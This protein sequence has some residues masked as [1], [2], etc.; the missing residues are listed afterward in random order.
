MSNIVKFVSIWAIA[1]I[2]IPLIMLSIYGYFLWSTAFLKFSVMIWPS[3]LF[4]LA[5]QDNGNPGDDQIRVIAILTNVVLYSIIGLIVWFVR[6]RFRK[7]E[8]S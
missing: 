7:A 8:R 1:G 4:L 2:T 6:S 3:S 5:L